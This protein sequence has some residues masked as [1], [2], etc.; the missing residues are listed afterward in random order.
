[1]PAK[2]WGV[3]EMDA[4]VLG[5]WGRVHTQLCSNTEEGLTDFFSEGCGKGFTEE[6]VF[7]VGLK[8]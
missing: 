7:E 1:M 4:G 6:A 8:R 5:A 2:G 3:M